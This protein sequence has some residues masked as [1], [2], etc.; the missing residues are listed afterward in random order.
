[1]SRELATITVEQP[2]KRKHIAGHA[3]YGLVRSV[4]EKQ[5]VV[6]W[7]YLSSCMTVEVHVIP[8][9]SVN[10][11][12]AFPWLNPPHGVIFVQPHGF[13]EPN[14]EPIPLIAIDFDDDD[15]YDGN[16][17]QVHLKNYQRPEAMQRYVNRIKP[18]AVVERLLPE[19]IYLQWEDEGKG[20]GVS[21]SSEGKDD[22]MGP[23]VSTED[24][25]PENALRGS[26]EVLT[27]CSEAEEKPE[28]D[29]LQSAH[30][31]GT[32]PILPPASTIMTP[33]MEWPTVETFYH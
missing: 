7:P 1:V 24:D 22:H 17:I 25:T 4:E 27:T 6:K 31:A 12:D 14:Y 20:A 26:T 2:R 15:D 11:D 30:V 32:D 16:I 29:T 28:S 13:L 19:D 18:T 21:D 33:G 8:G 23:A 3:F 5:D 10:W 9:F